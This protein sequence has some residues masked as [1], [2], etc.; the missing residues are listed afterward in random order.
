MRVVAPERGVLLLAI[1]AAL[2]T[3]VIGILIGVFGVPRAGGPLG[4]TED[5][6]KDKAFVSSV[7]ERVDPASLRG[8]LQHLSSAPH[9]AASERDRELVTWIRQ[10]WEDAGLE[11][12]SL[13]EYNILLSYP[14][15]SQ[16]NKIYLLDA[17][18]N[19]QFTSRHKEDTSARP[20]DDHP[21]FIHAFNAFS[22]PGDVT[23][24]LVYVN[25]GTVEDIKQ[26]Q[27]LGVSLQGRI[28][29]SR[30]GKIFRGNRLKNCETAGAIGLIMY[31]DPA[32]YATAGVNTSQVYPNT[33]FLPESG[34]QRGSTFIGDGEPLS[35][36]WPSVEGALRL[37]Q[38]DMAGRLPGIPAQPI[39]YG[40]ARRLLEVMG[41]PEVPEEWRG[42]LQGLT[43]R[44][45]PGNNEEHRG[46][47]VRLVTHNYMEDKKDSN[48]MGI[49]RGREEPDR[50]VLLSN[51]RDAWGYGAI[52]PSSGTTSLMEVARVLGMLHKST[53][54]R[55]RR[56]IVFASWAAEEYGLMGSNEWVYDR[57]HKVMD[58]AVAIINVDI[59][60]IGDILSPKASPILKDVFLDAIKA[61]PSTLDPG[62]TY[63]QFLT[64]WLARGEKTKD[65]TVEE[66]VK[67]LGSGSDHASFSFY[68]G[69]PALYFSFRTDEQK[70]PGAGYPTY[71][72]GFETFYLMDTILDPG[73]ALHRSCSQLST[74]MLLQLAESALLPLATSHFV[75]EVEK[76][77][78]AM[79]EG[80]AAQ[81]LRDL[82]LQ[83]PYNILLS[84]IQDFKL[85]A[86]SWSQ[87]R[88]GMVERG[89][90]ADP[91]QARM[92]NDQ[93]MKLERVWLLGQGLPDRPEIRHAI[94]SP[95]KFNSYG[96]A[97]FPGIADLL[98]EVEELSP[99][100][101]DQR[102]TKL[103][104][105]L[106]DLMIVFRQAA[107]WLAPWDTI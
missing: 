78:K 22:P 2:S 70:Y 34:I 106:S 36:G 1:G 56:T 47:K 41:G 45:G 61:I 51:H 10:Q 35:P 103:R 58:R 30:Y 69:V 99:E 105:H 14:N 80:T 84:S 60:I 9:I 54:W 91:L 40:D 6:F 79:E 104:R 83:E 21:D 65:T 31:S 89:E 88:E 7:L 28:A 37:R 64:D 71:H 81:Q 8:F 94:F 66:Y 29:I 63:Y 52:D 17:E 98:H 23:G 92:L 27:E 39:G 50:Y 101:R 53:G 57:I 4:G 85:A 93:I 38:E 42:G 82:G 32:K 107:S 48:V 62:K 73:F 18:D 90:L 25:Y 33:F 75:A 59:C 5:R 77:L 26:L 86:E 12:V 87:A 3:L 72:S 96:G 95:A 19:V 55:P 67:I 43:Y 74:H 13:S 76:G 100:E 11:S 44:L 15:S 68:A 46:W 20:E 102:T 49:I 24:E 16:P 97:A